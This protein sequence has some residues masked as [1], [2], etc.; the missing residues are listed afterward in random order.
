VGLEPKGKW[1]CLKASSSTI[2]AS[3][4]RDCSPKEKAEESGS[5][6]R[7][8]NVPIHKS[9]MLDSRNWKTQPFYEQDVHTD[10]RQRGLIVGGAESRGIH[11]KT[12]RKI[13]SKKVRKRNSPLDGMVASSGEAADVKGGGYAR[14]LKRLRSPGWGSSPEDLPNKLDGH[15]PS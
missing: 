10:G 13:T 3:G 15:C 12:G 14:S 5:L 8:T 9:R 11:R 4:S 7:K 6:N 2:G 1:H